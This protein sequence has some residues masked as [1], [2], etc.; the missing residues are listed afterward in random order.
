MFRKA[1]LVCG[2][3]SS[4]LYAAMTVFIARQWPGYSSA[5][6]TISELSAIG[7]PTRPFWFPVGAP[8]TVLVTAFGCGV[9]NTAGRNRAL[10]IAG[11]LILGYGSLGLLWPLAPMHM[12]NALAGGESRRADSRHIV[13]RGARVLVE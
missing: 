11:G 9:W 8:Y 5:S 2:I 13:R 1:L 7:A 12:R 10:R 4:M 3:L 6:H